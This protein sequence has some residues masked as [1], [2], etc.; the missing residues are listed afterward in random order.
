[1][2]GWAWVCVVITSRSSC[3]VLHSTNIARNK[4][5]SNIRNTHVQEHLRDNTTCFNICQAGLA[6]AEDNGQVKCKI[7]PLYSSFS[8]LEGHP[9]GIYLGS[10]PGEGGCPG[11]DGEQRGLSV[12]QLQ[13]RLADG[14]LV[15]ITGHHEEEDNERGKAKE[16]NHTAQGKPVHLPETESHT[17]TA[18][19]QL[20]MIAHSSC[21]WGYYVFYGQPIFSHSL[22]LY[23]VRS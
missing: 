18:W 9:D 23:C 8:Y 14:A 11:P 12:V 17:D 1:M 19:G 6:R 2:D 13:Q 3:S 22:N 4:L 10:W 15:L 5:M 20:K 16:A 21:D 7:L